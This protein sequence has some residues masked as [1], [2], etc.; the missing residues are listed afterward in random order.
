[1]LPCKQ[2]MSYFLLMIRSAIFLARFS[3]LFFDIIGGNNWVLSVI[4]LT[5][6][7]STKKI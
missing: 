2:T 1:M 6:K 7:L 4:N 3:V 5:L